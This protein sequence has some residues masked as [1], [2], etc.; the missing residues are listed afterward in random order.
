MFDVLMPNGPS[1]EIYIS[2]FLRDILCDTNF[3]GVSSSDFFSAQVIQHERYGRQA[4]TPYVCIDI[5]LTCE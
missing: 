5:Y 4:G 1:F 3:P 2:I